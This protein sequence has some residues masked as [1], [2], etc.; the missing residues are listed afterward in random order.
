LNGN[1][2]VTEPCFFNLDVFEASDS[3]DGVFD[4]GQE[5]RAV[6]ETNRASVIEVRFKWIDP[7]GNVDSITTVP[8]PSDDTRKAEDIFTPDEVGTWTVVADFGN[9][10]EIIRTLHVDFMVIPESPI[11]IIA[12]MGSILAAFGGYA[13]LRQKRSAA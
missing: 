6:A 13:Y 9:G 10:D 4:L 2:I 3:S 7:S 1:P 12:L 5:A 8:A 11:G